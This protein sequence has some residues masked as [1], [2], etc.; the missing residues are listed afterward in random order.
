MGSNAFSVCLFPLILRSMPSTSQTELDSSSWRCKTMNRLKHWALF[1]YT[2]VL[3]YWKTIIYHEWKYLSYRLNVQVLKHAHSVHNKEIF[4]Y[5][6]SVSS[7]KYHHSFFHIFPSLPNVEIRIVLSV[8]AGS[9]T[10]NQ[11]SRQSHL[12]YT[13]LIEQAVCIAG[14]AFVECSWMSMKVVI[15]FTISDIDLEITHQDCWGRAC[16]CRLH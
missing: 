14:S 8:L 1:K 4:V 10:S 15:H 5:K 16:K 9:P 6:V 11:K 13:L 12:K 3:K 7:F 2:E